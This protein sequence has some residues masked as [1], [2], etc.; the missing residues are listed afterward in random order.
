MFTGLVETIGT[1]LECHTLDTSSAGGNDVSLVIGDC[2][3][4]LV[5]VHLGDSISTNGVCL[6]VT[7]FNESKTFFKVGLAPETLRRSNLGEL[8][9]GLKVNLERAVNSDVRMGGHVVQGHVDTIATITKKEADGNSIAYTFQLRDQK[10]I[11]YIVEKGFVAVDGTSLTVTNVDYKSAS[12]S[13]ML[14]SYS[15]EKVILA[16]KAVGG[17]VNIEVDYTGK[18][19][20]KQMNLALEGQLLN[21]ESALSKFVSRMVEEKIQL[22]MKEGS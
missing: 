11:N 8:A 16:D 12:F 13:I 10:E 22:L 5:D 2:A 15:Q 19:I 3:E 9:V 17:T 1:V 21:E 4:I 6:T 18:L 20:E 7:E 14:V